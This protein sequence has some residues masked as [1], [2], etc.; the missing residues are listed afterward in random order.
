MANTGGAGS[1]P[2]GSGGSRQWSPF[3]IT[4]AVAIPL[5]AILVPVIVTVTTSGSSAPQASTRTGA[6]TVPAPTTSARKLDPCLF[7]FWSQTDTPS[8]TVRLL[9]HSPVKVV[10]AGGGTSIFYGADGH[11]RI[12][13]T[14]RVTG[15]HL[16][17][18]V[19]ADQQGTVAFTYSVENGAVQYVRT[20]E[21]AKEILYIDGKNVYTGPLSVPLPV[22]Q[23]TCGPTTL[24]LAQAGGETGHFQRPAT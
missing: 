19:E 2:G 7:G 15:T 4:T 18:A 20:A 23:V 24:V 17:K 22:Q 3:A 21:T 11:G 10:P 16:G 5:L 1:A 8:D 9:D 13:L 6:P 14:Q 12:D